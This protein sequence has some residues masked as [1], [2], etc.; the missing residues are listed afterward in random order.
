MDRAPLWLLG[1]PLMALVFV[2]LFLLGENCV[3]PIHDQLD[4]TLLCYMLNAKY[5]GQG[6]TRFPELLC[7]VNVNGMQPSALLFILL[8]KIFPVLTAFLIQYTIV[9]VTAFF[10]MYFCTKELTGSSILALVTGGCFCM[11]PYQPVY[12]LS[13]AGVPL[14]LLCFVCL[15]KK[16]HPIACLAGLTFFGLTTHLVLIGYVVLGFVL[17]ALIVS[18]VKK[19]F[20]GWALIGFL[21]LTAVYVF[22]NLSLFI[23]LIIG[24]S[25]FT[26]HREELVNGALPFI[27]TVKD[28]FLHSSQHAESLH[29]YLILPICAML[30]GYLISYRKR[31]KKQKQIFWVAVM[32]LAVLFG[33]AV[34][35]GIC[36]S[37]PVA[38]F[39][40]QCHGF[41]RYFQ[42][43]RLYF[44][45]PAGWLLEF[46][47][48]FS[49]WWRGDNEAADKAGAGRAAIDEAGVDSAVTNEVG[50]DGAV[51]YEVAAG[52]ADGATT[53]ETK[54]GP[55]FP[56]QVL[57][58]LILVLLLF[59]TLN[60]IKV[61]SYLY[62][63]V[64]QYNN[65]SAITGY[66][67][68]KSYYS[69]ELMQELEEAV[70]RDKSTYRIVHLGVSPAPSL[71]H[72]FYTVDG[73]SNNYPLEYKHRFRKVMEKELDKSPAT[74]AYFDDWGSR[75]YLFT[76]ETGT[77][78]MLGKD[79]EIVY[80]DFEPDLD[81]LKDLGCEYIFSCGLIEDAEAMG[82]TSLGYFETEDSYWGIW[83][84][85]L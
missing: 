19:E 69:E 39:K 48:C 67:S 23:Q 80:R 51:A 13:V 25:G 27:S 84:Y 60:L 57:K 49:L 42:P 21:W 50:V 78:W 12:G 29:S 38:E 52:E 41:F 43:E 77:A 28:V 82:L 61:N 64:N 68:W 56:L 79:K 40:N 73:Y 85:Q 8:Y 5:L 81:A 7:G 32:G 70:G 22:T 54:A 36:K 76:S 44:I 11:L 9:F 24:G 53:D 20:R 71:M 74:A 16:K 10:G 83:L 59:P 14:C 45:Y 15:W 37:A 4:E 17:L 66:I 75:C 58:L 46:A 62:L 72:G 55:R 6:V 18:A 47:L 2:P 65:G 26:S 31:E 1:F 35:Y 30:F 63:N 34:F 3:F 33:C